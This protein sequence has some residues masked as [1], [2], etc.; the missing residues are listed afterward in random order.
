VREA[1]A[2][3]RIHHPNV[4]RLFGTGECDGV[5]YIVMEYLDG[6]TLHAKLRSER[7]LTL[8]RTL[9][10][11]LP[12][13]H[14][15]HAAHRVGVTHR[16]VKPENI[17]L[18][19]GQGGRVEPKLLDFGVSL[20][21]ELARITDT[22]TVFGTPHYMA[23]EQT[24]GEVVGP[25]ADQYAM[26]VTIFEAL[27]GQLPYEGASTMSALQVFAQVAF[28]QPLR[29]DAVWPEAPAG[30]AD[31]LAR[32]LARKAADRY[33]TTTDFGTALL[34]VALAGARRQAMASSVVPR[35]GDTQPIRHSLRRAAN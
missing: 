32:A 27:T 35:A 25:A 4:V 5:A 20:V 6:V 7:V 15:L 23:P 24:R 12:M 13:L 16:D 9:D 30:L 22:S 10:I 29:L 1:I 18:A 34:G 8:D 26:A 19:R 11:A 33:A 3:S 28:G 14:A 17:L 2:A 31:V 21:A